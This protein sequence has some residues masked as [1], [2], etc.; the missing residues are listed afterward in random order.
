MS[1]YL[2]NAATSF[3][4]PPQVYETIRENFERYG[5]SPG[6]GSYRMAREASAVVE[7]ARRLLATLFNIDHAERIVFTLNA[8]DALNMAVKGALRPG[9]HAI[10]TA[11]EHNSVTRPLNRLA[12]EGGVRVTVVPASTTGS[13]DP[14]D[15]RRALTAQT[16]LVAVVHGSNVTGSLQ[17]IAELGQLVRGHGALF[18]VDASQTAGAVPID[19]EEACIDLL[20][21]PGHKA[22]L[23]PSGTGLLYVG[24]R[25]TLH[26]WREGGTGIF[27]EEPLQPETFPH[28]MESGSP[29]TLGLAGLC[30]SARYLLA[31]GIV[32]I[33]A[34][35]LALT[36]QLLN[37]LARN[38]HVRVHGPA[39]K[40]PR[41]GVVS[42]SLEDWAPLAVA[43]V[44][45]E[46]FG[47]AVRAGLHCAPGA[48]RAIGT[49]PAGTV[50][51]SPGPFT[52]AAEIDACL[53]A[54]Q[55]IAQMPCRE[56]GGVGCGS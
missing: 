49:F 38:P 39:P 6:R 50:R 34:H 8:T 30:E 17:P 45:D 11:L 47:I 37:G 28:A 3:P 7:E 25:V 27:S 18:L 36:T 42:L 13:I 43:E 14:A 54:L 22:L 26:P 9:D 5:A 41:V 52:T 16:R 55:Q 46:R 23:A 56:P 51:I 24:P 21:A 12:A 19:V 15:I 40:E 44:L 53:E 32:S 1:I 4:K 33:Q 29:N 2:D 35:E 48:H 31:R 20:A 10:M